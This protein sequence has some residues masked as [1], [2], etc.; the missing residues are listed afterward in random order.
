MQTK[1]MSYKQ[2]CQPSIPSNLP[3]PDASK[4]TRTHQAERSR[5]REWLVKD[6]CDC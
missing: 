2:I 3:E 1:S 5:R 6:V 4:G